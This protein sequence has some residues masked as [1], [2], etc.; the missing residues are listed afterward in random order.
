MVSKKLFTFLYTHCSRCEVEVIAFFFFALKEELIF[1]FVFLVA[2][3]HHIG[4]NYQFPVSKL[5]LWTA[6][7]TV[8]LA[9]GCFQVIR[10]WP[11]SL[12][13]D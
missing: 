12:I 9:T 4:E 10:E 13:I 6:N 5:I 8:F 2:R 3:I 1:F 11:M 7:T